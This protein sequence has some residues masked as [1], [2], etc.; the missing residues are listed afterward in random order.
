MND[1]PMLPGLEPP[2]RSASPLELAAHRTIQALQDEGLLEPRHA[3]TCQLILD[4]SQAVDAGK[5]AGRASA[6]AMAAAQLREAFLSLPE[7][8]T[9]GEEGDAWEALARELGRAA[10]ARDAAES[11]AT[12]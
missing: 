3:L 7:P 1:A 5:R 9:G 12:D 2:P 11:G 6:V 8:A 4:L 10:A